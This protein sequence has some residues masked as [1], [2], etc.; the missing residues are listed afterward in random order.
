MHPG[1]VPFGVPVSSFRLLFLYRAY[2]TGPLNQNDQG[3]MA[4][5]TSS[6]PEGPWS[7][8]VSGLQVQPVQT[9]FQIH[10]LLK[11]L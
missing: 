5:W 3:A 2:M 11:L 10:T 7:F 8:K 4:L 9:V 1:I 6:A